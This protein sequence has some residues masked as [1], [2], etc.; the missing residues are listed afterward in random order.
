MMN[1]F[2]EWLAKGLRPPPAPP[3]FHPLNSWDLNFPLLKLTR[4]DFFTV[5]NAVEGVHI[6]GGNGSGK[7]SGPGQALIKAYMRAGMGMLVLTAKPGEYELIRKYAEDTGCLKRVIRFAPEEPWRFNFMAYLQKLPS[8]G[9][10]L[11][12]NIVSTLVTVQEAMD[13]GNEGGNRE[14]YWKDTLNELLTNTVDLCLLAR[15]QVNL[16]VELLHD[17]ISSAPT[18][19]AQVDDLNWQ[20]SSLCYQLVGEA[21]NNESLTPRQRS[22]LKITGKYFLSQFPQ[23]AN[24]TRS[25][26]VSTF[27]SMISGLVRGPMADLIGTNLNITPE[28][29][30]DG[31]IVCVD[32]P[33]KSFG[34]LGLAVQTLWKF[35]WQE[36]I[37]RRDVSKNQRP[38]ALIADE[39]HLF[40]NEHDAL[41]AT[42]SRSSRACILFLSQTIANYTHSL[43][44]ESKAK[45]L[46]SS[47]L[48]VLQTK[49]FC[50]NS[51]FESNTWASNTIGKVW[52]RKQNSGFNRSEAGGGTSSSGSTESLD[53]AVEPM[54]FQVLKKG[55]P[56]NHFIVE[57]ICHAGGRIFK[58]NGKNHLLTA[59]DQKA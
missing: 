58:A 1:M 36:A 34:K 41:F 55:G 40:V 48:D 20:A 9:G 22:D 23:L 19:A 2:K 53:Y 25:S 51:S 31:F 50:A 11:T 56:E 37:E 49:F 33:V 16:S 42:T 12:A 10:G 28:F 32:V 4:E 29:T 44:G 27:T 54:V 17:V 7:T 38:V 30:L 47:L 59:F 46:T 15:P 21:L 5:G 26:I 43:G 13:K 3:A 6:S 39:A 45:A 18:S 8:R 52:G 14:Q 35:I 24:E 57:A